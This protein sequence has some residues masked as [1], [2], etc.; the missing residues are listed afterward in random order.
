[1]KTDPLGPPYSTAEDTDPERGDSDKGTWR[2][3]DFRA[4]MWQCGDWDAELKEINRTST[5]EKKKIELETQW[6]D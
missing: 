5:N 2:F 6:I 1:M 4:R 3:L